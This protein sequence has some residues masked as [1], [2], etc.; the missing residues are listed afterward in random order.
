M[1]DTV[2]VTTRTS[3]F[4]RLK[5]SVIG[6]LIGLLLVVGM[7]VLLFWNEGRAVQTARSLTEGAGVVVS[8]SSDAVDPAND[9]KLVHVTGDVSTWHKPSDPGFGITAEG[10]RLE[11]RAEMFQWKETSESKSQDKLGGGQETVTTYTYSKVWSDGPIDSS[12]FK[13]PAGHENP[14]ME[15]RGQ[16]FQVPEAE[17]GAFSLSQRVISMIGA[18]KDFPVA[19]DQTAAVDAAYSGNKRVTVAE[20]R[21]YLGFNATQPAVGDYRIS[22]RLAPLG[23]ISVIG[24]QAGSGFD[25][26]QTQAGDALLMVDDGV[27]PAEK[28]FAD[29]QTANTLVTWIIR[30]VGLIFLWVGFALV[31]APL[32][33]LAAVIP[34]L[35]QM[36]GFGAGLVALV[37]AVLVGAGTIAIAW[38]WYR[39]LLA[40][41]IIAAGVAIAFLLG[42]MGRARA[43]VAASAA[44]QAA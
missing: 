29:A 30:V 20:G 11:R 18:Q 3:W 31:M 22:Y 41:G 24:K 25:S 17:L 9:G 16:N 38:F 42:R 4:G 28:M 34:P 8:V 6:V 36:V 35:G 14:P 2:T 43:K 7:V 19:P 33:A 40:L 23:P 32:G 15:I 5:N 10:V 39:P 21:I 37:L 13:Q 26:Y 27:V 12:R 44:P 1:T